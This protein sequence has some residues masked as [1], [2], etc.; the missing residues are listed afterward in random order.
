MSFIAQLNIPKMMKMKGMMGSK[1]HSDF[2]NLLSSLRM[3]EYLPKD[4]AKKLA[5]KNNLAGYEPSPLE[6]DYAEHVIVNA[7]VILYKFN[8]FRYATISMMLGMLCI[9]VI[10]VL[11]LG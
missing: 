11:N 4:Y 6:I 9:I 10:K 3:A 5:E 1:K 7:K 2:D 8:C